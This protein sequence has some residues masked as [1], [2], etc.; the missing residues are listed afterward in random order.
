MT[1]GQLIA[2]LAALVIGISACST[3]GTLESRPATSPTGVSTTAPRNTTVP[4]RG[5][6]DG[7]PVW[8][9]SGATGEEAMAT[10]AVAEDSVLLESGATAPVE[11]TVTTGN[12]P[13]QGPLTG[14]S[15]DDN[16]EFDAYLRYRDAVGG[17]GVSYRE[18]DP[19][20]R[21]V[22]K[23]TG[24]NGLPVTGAAVSVTGQGSVTLHTTADGIAL[25]HPAAYG[26]GTGPFTVEVEGS[27]AQVSP[28][29]TVDLVI[30]REGGARE[31][32][33]LDILFLLDTTGSMDD[34][35]AQ[36]KNTISS[37]A[38][39]IHE[40]PGGPDT[41][42]GMTVYRDRGDSFLTGTFDFTSDV[43]AF[44]RALADVRADGGGDYPE[45]V[46]EALAA[47]LSEPTWRPAESTVQL[48]FLVA[49]APPHVDRQ[50]AV[51]YTE[52]MIE[53]RSRGIKILPVSS[54]GTDD[55]AEFVFRQLAQF[56]G[57]R[58]VFLTYGAQGRATGDSTNI[59]ELGYE[60]LAL[61][62]L[63]VRMVAEELED[64]TSL[65]TTG[66]Q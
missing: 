29:G 45:A 55:Q 3:K 16:A 32:I 33:A 20:G 51:P 15:V 1:S 43:A 54:S 8:I 19:T 37:V 46:D 10:R 24:T 5:W 28:G 30:G 2:I 23:V 38:N 49:D 56:T 22:I 42:I 66:R 60:E 14:G 31:P 26:A 18:L 50:V 39:R 52:S 59:D 21:I 12:V 34:E 6:I 35:I 63:I 53:A 36:L 57:G 13:T 4:D 25:F 17:L 40:L 11:S 9:E 27:S 44:D 48:I 7:E 65:K 61:D 64:L 41:R 58:Y 47:S 62:D